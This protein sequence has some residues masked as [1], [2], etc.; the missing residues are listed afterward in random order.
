MQHTSPSHS[1]ATP[2]DARDALT[3]GAAYYA[4]GVLQPYS[5][6]GPTNDGRQK[7]EVL[8]PD[9][10]QVATYV[11]EPLFG[12]SA[13]APHIAAAAALVWEA[14]PDFTAGD[15]R[16]FLIAY[17]LGPAGEASG[18]GSIRLPA[19]PQDVSD[20]GELPAP[21]EPAPST[22]TTPIGSTGAVVA[23]LLTGVAVIVV[24][25]LWV[26]RRRSVTQ[27]E[28]STRID[29][30][31]CALCGL[32]MRAAAQFCSQCGRPFDAAASRTCTHCGQ[33]LRPAAAYCSQCGHTT[34]T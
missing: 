8:G 16:A 29:L 20:S 10:V 7:P 11:P 28:M 17:T 4:D 9:G 25:S 5:S 27:D 33:R 14:Y 34:H 22:S 6:Y 18:A 31:T 12:T 2:A 26:L 13:S 15:V 23:F 30:K 19:P 32:Q 3:V 21:I 24:G 1:L